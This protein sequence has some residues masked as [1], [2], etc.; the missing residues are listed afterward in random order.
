MRL[1]ERRGDA[2]LLLS[3]ARGPG[4][5]EPRAR[6]LDVV[7]ATSNYFEFDYRL[8]IVI[9][10]LFSFRS[11][12]EIVWFSANVFVISECESFVFIIQFPIK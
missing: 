6:S 4:P 11:F 2:T 9:A 1:S 5:V 10:S 3:V 7:I 12:E 8:A